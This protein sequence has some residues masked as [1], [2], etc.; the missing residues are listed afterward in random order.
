MFISKDLYD[1]VLIEPLRRGFT[2]LKIISGYAS[3]SMVSKHFESINELIKNKHLASNI[4]SIELIV[5]MVLKDGININDYQGFIE[6]QT[7]LYV[8]K[9]ECKYVRSTPAVHSKLY[10]WSNP[11]GDIEAY[12][13]SA[14]FTQNAFLRRGNDEILSLCDGNA[15]MSY[16][17]EI[18]PKTIFCD[19]PDVEN[20]FIINTRDSLLSKSRERVNNQEIKVADDYIG[21]RVTLTLLDSKT[22]KE[23]QKSGLNWGQREGREKN[24]AYIAIP[25]DINKT[26]FFPGI[27]TNF[28]LITDDDKTLIC[29]RAQQNGKAIHTTQNNS[30]MGEYFRNR[31]NLHSGEFITKAHLEQYGKTHVTITKI[32]EETYFLDFDPHS[33]NI[34]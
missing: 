6:S 17:N 5:G 22:G 8:G 25:A 14:N 11:H 10:I 20:N 29:V 30:L 34:T 32:D 31:L 1:V 16:Y 3:V 2:D 19:H 27:G 4:N 9:F 13:G 26:V 23:P 33:E 28:S 21:A 12:I 7:K 15:A 24:Q 18:E